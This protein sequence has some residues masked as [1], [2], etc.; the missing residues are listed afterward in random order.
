V[1]KA[2]KKKELNLYRRQ[3]T[4]Y[5]IQQVLNSN[6]SNN[7][8]LHLTFIDNIIPKMT[9]SEHDTKQL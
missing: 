1:D 4:K 9:N 5:H 8:V 3:R 2:K 6:C 7:N